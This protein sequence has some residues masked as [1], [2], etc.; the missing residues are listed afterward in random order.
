VHAIPR[1]L[2]WGT[3]MTREVTANYN[4]PISNTAAGMMLFEAA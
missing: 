4:I 1:T 3:S 2:D